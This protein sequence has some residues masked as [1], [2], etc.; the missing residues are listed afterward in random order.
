MSATQSQEV[1][2]VRIA[3][4]PTGSPHV[5]TAYIALYNYCFAKSRGGQFVLRIEDTD[6]SRSKPVYEE[7]ILNAL[8]WTGL[9]WDEGPDVGGPH[10]PY[11]QS[12]RTEIYRE[13]LTRL[14]DA[15]HAYKCFCTPQRLE[16]LREE[17]RA[18]G[19]HIGYDGLCGRL[20]PAEIAARE[21]ENLP[22]TV[23]MRI[24]DD[25]VCTVQDPLRGEV[26][27]EYRLIDHQVLMKSDGFPTY[28][29]ANVVDDHL[30]GITHVIR[31]EEW[32]PSLPKHILLYEYFGWQA[33]QVIHLPLLRNE[34][35]SK[36]SKRKNPTS[37]LYY[38]DLGI[39]P[40]ALL[41]FL[42]TMA[43][44]QPDGAEVF[45]LDEMVASFDIQRMSLGGP[46]FT[47]DKLNWL[48]Q[49]HVA[50]L[51][52][53]EILTHLKEWRFNDDFLRRLIPVMSKRIHKLGDFMKHCDFFF[54]SDLAYDKAL[55]APKGKEPEDTRDFLQK[56]VWELE[57]VVDFQKEALEAAIVKVAQIHGWNLRQAT[58]AVRVA[59][60]GK[61]VA[62][63]MFE[64]L[65]IVG[66]D[67]SRNRMMQAIQALGPLGK[68]K[69]KKLQEQFQKDAAAYT[70][71]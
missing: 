56:L 33:P 21:A 14:L 48:N 31:G 38:R 24:P 15:G 52:E 68:K 50:T 3:P 54:Y 70:P 43:Y 45:S 61:T 40:K 20:E 44:S 25:G 39:L 59:V 29:L 1:T 17:Q 53:D 64:V 30:M 2:R 36:L 69:L 47:L 71:E 42:G 51:S 55:L 35:G 28:H 19:A 22:Y 18:A 7:M 4:S 5:G 63:P 46:I 23:R 60:T 67:V 13:H 37:I 34:D 8:R 66:S 32:L 57:K 26:E 6:Q 9:S 49:K 16:A 65:E 62:P 58:H 41:N 27:F 10:G 11:R 12:E